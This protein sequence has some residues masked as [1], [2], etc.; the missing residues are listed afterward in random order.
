MNHL[1]IKNVRSEA[2][3]VSALQRT[4]HPSVVQIQEAIARA[5]RQFGG[6]GCAERVAQEFGDHPEVAVGRMQWAREAIDGAFGAT[7]PQAARATRRLAARVRPLAS[8][9]VAPAGCAA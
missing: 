1:S 5:V 4:D 2:L 3:F 8:P 7:R 9:V 6:R